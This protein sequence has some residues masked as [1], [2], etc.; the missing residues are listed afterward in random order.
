[1]SK[2][3]DIYPIA[4]EQTKQ[5]IYGNMDRYM[6]TQAE[7]PEFEKYLSD[8]KIYI[9]QIWTDLWINKASNDV[10][11]KE[12]KMYLNE[13]GY[14]T[15]GVDHKQIS[16]LFRNKMKNYKPFNVRE[17]L[18]KTHKENPKNW[19][20]RYVKARGSFSKFRE[21]QKNSEER[22]NIQSLLKEKTDNFFEKHSLSLYVHLRYQMAKQ[23][24]NDLLTKPKYK[25]MEPYM[26]EERLDIVGDFNHTE[27]VLV[28]EFLGELTGNIHSIFDWGRRHYEYETYYYR[29]ERL[30]TDFISDFAPTKVIE[31]LSDKMQLTF[32][33]AYGEQLKVG[34][35]KKLIRDELA[36]LSETFYEELQEEFLSDLL[37]L[38]EFPFD[39]Q[40]HLK[41]FEKD[42]AERERRK[43]EEL[44]ELARLKAE[45]ERI[46]DDIFGQAFTPT[47]GKS[48]K[49]VLHIGET[50]SGKTHQALQKMKVA[51][52]GLYLAPL[53]LLALEIYDK[54][55]AEGI[56]CTLKTGEEEKVVEDAKHFSSTVEMFHERDFYEVIVIDEAQMIADKDRGFSWF[57]AIMKA[58]ANEVHIIGSRNI[59]SMLYDLLDEA[60]IEL[61][62]YSRDIPLE[63][64]PREF[65]LKQTRKGDAIVCFS[66]RKV[67]ETASLLQRNGHRVSIIYGSMPPENRKRQIQLFNRGETSV[68]VSTDA[69]GMGLN[70]P[71]QRIVLLENEKFDGTRRRRLNSQEVK[72]IAGRAGRKGI[73]DIGKVAFASDIQAMQRLLE[74]VDEPVQIFAIAPTSQ[75]FERFQKYYRNMGLFFEMWDQ[76]V[77]PKG[78]K[79]SSLSQEREL[80]ELIRDTEIEVRFSLMDLYGFLHLPFSGKEQGLVH[81]WFKTIKAIAQSKDLPEPV[82]ATKNL[83]DLE[84]S[85]KAIGLHLLFLYRINRRTE[86]VYWER[87]REEISNGVHD[88]LKDEVVHYQK[89]CKRCRKKLPDDAR[90]PICDE[91]HQSGYK[92]I[93]KFHHHRK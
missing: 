75:I 89:K 21:E 63:V 52:S 18:I 43:E 55:N 36:E 51:D 24:I 68:V 93:P 78:T 29:Y 5:K 4:I 46:I 9:E 85:Y 17:W 42:V 47:L 49:Y 70:L 34:F 12:K 20:Q 23:L 67:L 77:P 53:R 81:Q 31:L 74:Q 80:Y 44:A 60:E 25:N 72:Q 3:L 2:L 84:L 35:L 38:A 28:N 14:M 58:N 61:H 33:K 11:K 19:E 30:V 65:V 76:F 57:Q 50:N 40:Q 92:N 16:K 64:E 37:K 91:C 83:E 15:T 86:A 69:I 13:N 88:Q 10:P 79:K 48:M 82:I 54:L 62:E 41:I 32:S 87:I 59:K 90:F 66:R 73:Y 1:M 8:K 71:I 22:W 6:E 26:I 56:P 7:L 27:Y 45:K 39:E